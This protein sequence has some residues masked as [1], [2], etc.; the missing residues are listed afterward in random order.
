MS[1]NRIPQPASWEAGY[2]VLLLKHLICFISSCSGTRQ[3]WNFDQAPDIWYQIKAFWGADEITWFIQPGGDR[4][5]LIAV[6]NFLTRRRGRHWSLFY[7]D[8]WQEPRR[9]G[10]GSPELEHATKPVWVQE[11]F[12]QYSQALGVTLEVYWRGQGVELNDHDKSRPIQF[13]L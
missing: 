2:K 7:D 6:H 9:T 4:E 13:I 10:T 1:P 8:Q 11:V 5:A 3:A 12:G